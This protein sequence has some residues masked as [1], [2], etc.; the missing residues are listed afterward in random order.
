MP[1]LA[2]HAAPHSV[3]VRFDDSQGSTVHR[4]DYRWPDDET[5]AVDPDAYCSVKVP[6]ETRVGIA[7]NQ[8][9]TM[10]GRKPSDG[11]DGTILDPVCV[12]DSQEVIDELRRFNPW[13]DSQGK[14]HG[15]EGWG[16]QSI[17]DAAGQPIVIDKRIARSGLPIAG[18][19]EAYRMAYDPACLAGNSTWRETAAD[20][21][22]SLLARLAARVELVR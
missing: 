6:S 16:I 19:S 7:I 12:N 9:S 3:T 13:I 17:Y 5:D 18:E 20:C 1:L 15:G 21:I 4:I 22:E 14:A 2:A 11:I 8:W 10:F